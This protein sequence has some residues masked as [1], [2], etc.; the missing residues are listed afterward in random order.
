MH[1]VV[2]LYLSRA[3]LSYYWTP[4][5]NIFGSPLGL[6]A[7]GHLLVAVIHLF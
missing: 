3:S 7:Q 1:L 4:Q 6:Y 5:L 2:S